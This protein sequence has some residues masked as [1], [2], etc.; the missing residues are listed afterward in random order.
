MNVWGDIYRSHETFPP[1]GLALPLALSGAI[2]SSIIAGCGGGNGLISGTTAG[3]TTAGST[4]GATTAGATTGATTAGATTGAT[5]A[6]ATTGATT[7]GA[8]TGGMTGGMI[9]PPTTG[10]LSIAPNFTFAAIPGATTT[11]NLSPLNTVRILSAN[12]AIGNSM[13]SGPTT[14][15]LAIAANS[16]STANRGV[17]RDFSISLQ[18]AGRTSNDAFFR[19]QRI[20]LVQ[21]GVVRDDAYGTVTFSQLTGS[22]TGG[23]STNNGNWQTT[24]GTAIIRAIGSNSVTLEFENAVFVPR[25]FGGAGTGNFSL[26]GTVRAENLQVR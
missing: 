25:T 2:L 16:G 14:Q 17:Q 15:S 23:S 3:T 20:A 22:A 4:T 13:G 1:K 11:F 18:S 6:G 8:T 24:S 19:G 9:D 26:N 12:N 5:T 7:A 21:S 10:P